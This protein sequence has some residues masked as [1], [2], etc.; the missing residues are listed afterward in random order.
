VLAAAIALGVSGLGL[1]AAT[2]VCDPGAGTFSIVAYDS[3]TGELGVAVQSRAFS[4]GSRVA[5]ARAGVGAIATQSFTNASYGPRGLQLL[6]G[7]SSPSA[8]LDSL[9]S[10][11]LERERRQVGIVSARGLAANF[12]GK[13]CMEWAGGTVGVGFAAQGNILAGEAVVRQMALAF[14]NLDG[15]LSERLVAALEA[16][17]SAGGDKRGQQSAVLLVVRPSEEY[18]EYRERYVSLRVEDHPSPIAELKRLYRIH[19]ASGLAEAHVRYAAAYRRAGR[20]A[21]AER[22]MSRLGE[23]LRR[24]LADPA[25]AAGTLNE[26]AWY[27]CTGDVHLDEALRAAAR[28][29]EREPNS[30]EILDTVAECH[31][32]RGQYQEALAAIRRALVV[33]PKDEYLKSQEKKFEEA[34]KK[35]EKK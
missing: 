29:A 28:A 14:R 20:T 22:E 3:A 24:A 21:D 7:G 4:V 8:V 27:A 19:E 17:Q 10:L 5:W 16:A 25:T 6:A 9:L 18:P 23:T 2:A 12:T 13:E 34:K 32:R 11:D 26:L 1:G 35:A 31:Y 15:E 33:T 30:T